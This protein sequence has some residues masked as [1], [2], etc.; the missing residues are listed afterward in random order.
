MG[1]TH[2]RPAQLDGVVVRDAVETPTPC[3]MRPPAAR[4]LR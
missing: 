1:G 3:A 2:A 4:Q